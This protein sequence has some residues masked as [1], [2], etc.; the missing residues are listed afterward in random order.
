MKYTFTTETFE[1]SSKTKGGECPQGMLVQV[2]RTEDFQFFIWRDT[3]ELI[4]TKI[5]AIGHTSAFQ[6]AVF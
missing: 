2:S 6:V 1:H 3:V 4:R 5:E